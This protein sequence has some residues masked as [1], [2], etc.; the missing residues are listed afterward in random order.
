MSTA[1]ATAITDADARYTARGIAGV[2]PPLKR[3]AVA[4]PCPIR[5]AARRLG[6]NPRPE[7]F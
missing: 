1:T 7:R 3:A 2:L 4:T 5:E 6:Q